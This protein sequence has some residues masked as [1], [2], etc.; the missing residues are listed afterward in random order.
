[1]PAARRAWN[2]SEKPD[3]LDEKTNRDK[4]LPCLARVTVRTIVSGL[5]VSEPYATNSCRPV[6]SASEALEK[7]CSLRGFRRP[8]VVTE[9]LERD[10]QIVR[11]FIFDLLVC[12]DRDLTKLLLGE[13]RDLMKTLLGLRSPRVRIVEQ[14]EVTAS[15]MLAGVHQQQL[16]GVIAKR[17]DSLYEA[18]KRSGA[19]VKCRAN[20]GQE[21]VIGGYI[22]GPHGFDSLIV[23]YY[24]GKDLLY[25]ARVRNGFVPASRR[26]GLR[27]NP[28]FCVTHDALRQ[29]A[30]HAQVALGR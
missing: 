2:P 30:R 19:W 11:Y 14:F 27:E 20:R 10:A 4:V 12:N 26:A 16:E 6:H 13:R 9:L 25:V 7:A 24:Q 8:D 23:G 1:M 21:L 5:E 22:P 28:S 17:K 18:G 29:S 3:W 15:D